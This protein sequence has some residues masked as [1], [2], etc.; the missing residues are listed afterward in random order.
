MGEGGEREGDTYLEDASDDDK[1]Y[2]AIASRVITND[3]T[4]AAKDEDDEEGRMVGILQFWVREMG[5]MDAVAKSI[6]DRD[7]DCLENLTNVTC[8]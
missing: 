3:N 1:I 4:K 5:H 6:T 8:R 2:G 7:I